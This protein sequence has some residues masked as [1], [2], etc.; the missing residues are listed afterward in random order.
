MLECI[1]SGDC[2]VKTIQIE[3]EWFVAVHH[4]DIGLGVSSYTLKGIVHSHLPEQY[5]FSRR[6]IGIYCSY[7]GSKLFTTIPGGCRVILG[8][9][10]PDR[11]D[12]LD[13]LVERHNHLQDQTW[14]AQK[15]EHVVLDD[16]IPG[17][18][19][20]RKHIYFVFKLGELGLLGSKRVSYEYAC[21]WRY[22][23]HTKN[24]IN[25]FR[26][27]HPGSTITLKMVND[28]LRLRMWKENHSLTLFRCYF[29]INKGHN[30]IL[31][32]DDGNNDDGNG[33][34]TEDI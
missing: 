16:S 26:K 19:N 27:K 7:D 31:L 30:H 33:K 13:F 4:I 12:V 28:P 5:K 21:I 2:K 8:S 18:K 15:T 11:Y 9:K 3:N 23:W 20:Y 25:N 1:K 22:P 32:V 34:V 14:E 17:S 29:R 24:G 10:H 6:E